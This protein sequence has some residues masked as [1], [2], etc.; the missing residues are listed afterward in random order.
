MKLERETTW[1]VASDSVG[2]VWHGGLRFGLPICE[3]PHY[4]F[5]VLHTKATT[6]QYHIYLHGL[7]CLGFPVYTPTHPPTTTSFSII[8]VYCW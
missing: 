3:H 2:D 7:Y 4:K 6:K 5:L 1:I 8:H